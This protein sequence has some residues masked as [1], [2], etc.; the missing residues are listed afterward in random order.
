MK[1]GKNVFGEILATCCTSPMTG[2][3]RTGCCDTGP[4]DAGAHVVCVQVTQ[5]FLDFTGSKGNDLSTP[6]PAVGFPGLKPGDRWCVCAGRWKQ[7]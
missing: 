6:L 1:D 5:A 4:Q 3:F 2:Y 7:A